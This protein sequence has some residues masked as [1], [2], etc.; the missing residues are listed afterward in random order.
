MDFGKGLT[1]KF[2]QT[3]SFARVGVPLFIQRFPQYRDSDTTSDDGEHQDVDTGFTVFPCCVVEGEADV[4]PAENREDE[5]GNISSADK[6]PG[7]ETLH[8]AID[9]FRLGL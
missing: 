9:G 7:K 1:E 5:A 2:Q 6:V 3:H 4:L 8:T